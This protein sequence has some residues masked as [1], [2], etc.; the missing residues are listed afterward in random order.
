MN[1]KPAGCT[2]TI[3]ALVPSSERIRVF[4]HAAKML[5]PLFLQTPV[6][7]PHTPPHTPALLPPPSQPCA[8]PPP[9][10][11]RIW[12]RALPTLAAPAAPAGQGRPRRP[13]AGLSWRPQRT[14]CCSRSSRRGWPPPTW[15]S[16]RWVGGPSAGPLAT[17]VI[18]MS[19]RHTCRCCT[20]RRSSAWSCNWLLVVSS[21]PQPTLPGT[22]TPP[23]APAAGAP[24]RCCA[25]WRF[26]SLVVFFVSSPSQSIYPPSPPHTQ[27]HTHTTPTAP[28]NHP[29]RSTCHCCARWRWPSPA[30]TPTL[31]RWQT[32]TPRWTS[33]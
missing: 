10:L 3:P 17:L 1:A 14:A 33:S 16:G 5:P 9:R 30:A 23:A 24:V 7:L 32:R 8:T 12:W 4:P 31:Q 27:T 6:A 20:R 19:F 29:R 15:R 26:L 28:P 25:R 2:C 11:S 22:P 18:F 13:R 21:A